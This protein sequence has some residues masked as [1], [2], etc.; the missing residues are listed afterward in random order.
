MH[1]IS[2]QNSK[3]SDVFPLHQF[4]GN[5]YT[6]VINLSA[7]NWTPFQFG[8]ED[9]VACLLHLLQQHLDS[10]G[11]SARILFADFNSAFDTIQRHK[12]IQK[13]IHLSISSRLIQI[14]YDFFTNRQQTAPLTTNT[15]APQGCMLSP[16]LYTLYTNDCT[17]SFSP[18]IR[19]LKYA[20]NTVLLGLL[21]D[22]HSLQEYHDSMVQFR[23]K[24]NHHLNLNLK[25]NEWFLGLIHTKHH[26]QHHH[27]NRASFKIPWND[28]RQ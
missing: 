24:Q 27:R 18:T 23:C 12:L 2:S 13:L 5:K 3:T 17:T 15:G 28:N 20:D 8:Y 14:I 9:A 22:N 10:P 26:R 21:T 16:F 1:A 6:F 11:T 25:K 7:N 4:K 19:F